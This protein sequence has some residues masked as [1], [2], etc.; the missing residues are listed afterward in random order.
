MG[1]RRER[2]KQELEN[3]LAALRPGES[4]GAPPGAPQQGAIGTN[5]FP[6]STYSSPTN[7]L[8]PESLGQ[9]SRYRYNLDTLTPEPVSPGNAF[10]QMTG[11]PNAPGWQGPNTPKMGVGLPGDPRAGEEPAGM[12]DFWTTF[13]A[14]SSEL[15]QEHPSVGGINPSQVPLAQPNQQNQRTPFGSGGFNQL[16]S[17][18]GAA[19]DF[20]GYSGGGGG[21]GFTPGVPTETVGT[22]QG[23]ETQHGVGPDGDFRL[24]PA[25]QGLFQQ[26]GAPKA[27]GP[28]P[29]GQSLQERFRATGVKGL[30]EPLWVKRPGQDEKPQTGIHAPGAPPARPHWIRPGD[31]QP[32]FNKELEG[33][34]NQALGR[35][36]AAGEGRPI[37]PPGPYPRQVGPP[38]PAPAYV[39]G[40]GSPAAESSA[41]PE[42]TQAP[43]PGSEHPPWGS[44]PKA[45]WDSAA[46]TAPE[47]APIAPTKGAEVK[48]KTDA[49][50]TPDEKAAAVVTMGRNPPPKPQE[51]DRAAA[52]RTLNHARQAVRHASNNGG[53]RFQDVGGASFKEVLKNVS[54]SGQLN[55][56]GIG[57]GPD[58][59]KEFAAHEA[60]VIRL[61][62]QR[63]VPGQKDKKNLSPDEAKLYVLNRMWNH[64]RDLT[65]KNEYKGVLAQ[66]G[67]IIDSYGDVFNFGY[68]ADEMK[69]RATRRVA[70]IKAFDTYSLQLGGGS[71]LSAPEQEIADEVI[72][73]ELANISRS[74]VEGALDAV[75]GGWDAITGA[76]ESVSRGIRGLGERKAK[77]GRSYW[78]K[79]GISGPATR[80]D[81]IK[82]FRESAGQR[83]RGTEY[84]LG[85]TSGGNDPAQGLYGRDA[86]GT[87]SRAGG[88]DQTAMLDPWQQYIAYKLDAGGLTPDKG[89]YYVAQWV[90]DLSAVFPPDPKTGELSP[91]VQ[92][93]LREVK[94]MK[95]DNPET[96]GKV[97][98]NKYLGQVVRSLR[99]EDVEMPDPTGVLT[100]DA[101]PFPG[102]VE[103][104]DTGKLSQGLPCGEATGLGE[105]GDVDYVMTDQGVEVP[106]TGRE[107]EVQLDPS[108]GKWITRANPNWDD[109]V[110]GH[111]TPVL[112]EAIRKGAVADKE[113]VAAATAGKKAAAGKAAGTAG[114]AAGEGGESTLSDYDQSVKTAFK[115]EEKGRAYWDSKRDKL[116]GQG[117]TKEQRSESV[118]TV[119]KQVVGEQLDE[120]TDQIVEK[121][122]DR[123]ML[124]SFGKVV[125]EALVKI[126]DSIVKY[127]GGL[128]NQE[129][130]T[131][132]PTA[133]VDAIN[134]T[135]KEKEGALYRLSTFVMTGHLYPKG[136]SLASMHAQSGMLQHSQNLE[137]KNRHFLMGLEQQSLA[138]YLS[139]NE[140]I[141]GHKLSAARQQ[142]LTRQ[143][144]EEFDDKREQF[145]YTY[146][147]D[148]YK[149][150]IENAGNLRL[151]RLEL[152]TIEG[153]LTTID[154]GKSVLAAKPQFETGWF[155]NIAQTVGNY[156]GTASPKW[157]QFKQKV[158]T[159]LNTYVNRLTGKQLSKHEVGRLKGAVP[160]I[161]DN[162]AVF[163]A[164]C[165]TF[166]AI[167][168]MILQRKL[169]TYALNGHDVTPFMKDVPLN[170]EVRMGNSWVEKDGSIG[171]YRDFLQRNPKLLTQGRIRMLDGPQGNVIR[172]GE[173]Y[174]PTIMGDFITRKEDG[175]V[176]YAED[177]Y[178]AQQ[179]SEMPL[180]AQPSGTYY[181]QGVARAYDHVAA[182]YLLPGLRR[183][184]TKGRL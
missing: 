57:L 168:K 94:D 18:M 65:K 128:R 97:L 171:Q 31:G 21:G 180:G 20:P 138:S 61:H 24:K 152:D 134:A 54:I 29:P 44:E 53:V 110:G 19:G 26:P 143:W 175:G 15:G 169:R 107:N 75:T 87:P 71:S 146:A 142:E 38:A 145:A 136:T 45:P 130:P 27:F 86:A 149:A 148:R 170:W 106:T 177:R 182:P 13:G 123:T 104:A 67:E 166:I 7:S 111:R 147:L 178:G 101:P 85:S 183:G 72:N 92:G 14:D 16:A 162:D 150:N 22:P 12:K 144:T 117:K 83:Q 137:Q 47:S 32:D 99:G 155:V 89:P 64:M 153:L 56:G 126:G 154:M 127:S 73:N 165:K 173:E 8:S 119:A 55:Q 120:Q 96:A 23:P 52:T 114:A 78:W 43:P 176:Q 50:K 36:D 121:L 133:I 2:T 109:S 34:E 25:I 100:I 129:G 158:T 157:H 98:S 37:V 160:Q 174:L 66:Y 163:T 4:G 118:A 139:Y 5:M 159:Q 62:A 88:I 105:P 68:S 102:A 17:P 51:T 156:I 108:T 113:T 28:V 95:E 140:K 35:L 70:I 41:G 93:L 141:L 39:P 81:I 3:I 161:T 124:L 84:G 115:A 63:K 135:G 30:G 40:P 132:M 48:P 179:P 49:T 151:D 59:H 82:L 184:L 172:E 76:P 77:P 60:E 42:A 1:T 79:K 167:Q 33:L 91:E 164:K 131:M 9:P 74:P 69:N 80:N 112:P 11:D 103:E 90:K 46:D 6:A 10:G 122:R 181:K 116:F 58:F 125:T